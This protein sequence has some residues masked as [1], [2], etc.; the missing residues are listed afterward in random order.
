M[1]G[2]H[3]VGSI[4]VDLIP[5]LDA[6][7]VFQH[8]TSA[9]LHQADF[10]IVALKTSEGPASLLAFSMFYI[11]HHWDFRHFQFLACGTKLH[12]S[13]LQVY[14]GILPYCSYSTIY[15]TVKLYVHRRRRPQ[16]LTRSIAGKDGEATKNSKDHIYWNTSYTVGHSRGFPFRHYVNIC[17]LYR[18]MEYCT[19]M[20]QS[21]TLFC[22]LYHNWNFAYDFRT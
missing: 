22:F 4:A 17:T 14:A 18:R 2:Q 1:E 19:R 10:K 5:P 6:L 15:L 13:L 3:A 21:R 20:L 7:Q 16:I 11:G 9:K 12:C 8:H